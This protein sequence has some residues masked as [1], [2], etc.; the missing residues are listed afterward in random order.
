M[1][2]YVG[3]LDYETTEDDLRDVFAE[4]GEITSVKIIKDRE[5]YRSRGFGFVEM[6]SKDDALRAIEETHGTMLGRNEIVVNEAKPKNNNRGN[7]GGFNNRK[8]NS[9]GYGGGNR[10]SW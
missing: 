5:T 4:F 6:P 2:L 8:S 10:R 3:N 7:S 1:N 9:G